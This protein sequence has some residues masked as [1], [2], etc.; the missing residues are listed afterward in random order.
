VRLLGKL[1]EG[2][3]YDEAAS[4]LKNYL[5]KAEVVDPTDD[6]TWARLADHI[7]ELIFNDKGFQAS[8]GF[9][10]DL[11]EFF[12]KELEPET[13]H[14]HKGH[15]LFRLGWA[16]MGSDVSVGKSYFEEAV[17]EARTRE[18]KL[19]PEVPDTVFEE[20]VSEYSSYVTCCIIDRIGNEHFDSEEEKQR[21]FGELFS[22]SFDAALHGLGTHPMVVVKAIQD[23]VP[24]LGLRELG[25]ARHELDIVHDKALKI[26][27]VALT[28]TLLEGVLLGILLHQENVTTIERK[29]W[30]VDIRSVGLGFLLEEAKNRGVFPSAS[31]EAACRTVYIFRNRLHPGNELLQKYKITFRIASTLKTLLDLAL[32][33]WARL[34]KG[35]GLNGNPC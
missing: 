27:T 4:L 1:L 16:T 29:G 22:P 23:I 34:R 18:R 21:F 28:G 17:E 13:G 33:D 15:I 32:I 5:L 3:K 14:I 11:L 8:M 24:S 6:K 25:D 31:V 26:A 30:P 19:Y 9:W 2:K 10:K 35:G 12:K 7:A 20:L